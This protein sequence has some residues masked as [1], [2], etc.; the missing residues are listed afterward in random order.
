[1]I[2]QQREPPLAGKVQNRD[3]LFNRN[4]ITFAGIRRIEEGQKQG[5]LI[6]QNILNDNW[7]DICFALSTTEGRQNDGVVEEC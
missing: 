3:P 4:N 1:V 6:R 2:S 5:Q 7:A